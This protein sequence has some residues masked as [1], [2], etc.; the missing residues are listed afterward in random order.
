MLPEVNQK[1]DILSAYIGSPLTEEQKEFASD[2][3]Q[4]TVSFSDP[5]TGKTHTI[6][7]GLIV[8][9]TYHGVPGDKINCMSFTRA[10]VSEVA[11]R[12]EKLCK[13][14][15]VSPT[16]KF[17]TFHALSRVILSD[18]YNREMRIV[19]F[20]AKQDL[21]MIIGYMN[22]EGYTLS[23]DDKDDV[24]YARKVLRAINTLNS[25]LTFHPENV[26][27]R[28]EFV[29]LGMDI[30]KFTNIRT[31]M[32]VKG[33][34]SKEI[35]VG[36]IPLYCLYALMKRPEVVAK[37]QNKYR[38]MVVDEF[39]DMSLLHLQ[40]LS[41]IAQTLVVIGDMKQQIY[42]FNGA[43][44]QIVAAYRTMRPDARTV[45]LTQSFRCGQEVADFATRVILPNDRSIVPFKGHNRGSSVSIV[46]RRDLDWKQIIGELAM[47]K[48]VDGYAGMTDIMFLYRNNASAIPIIEELYKN[49][50]SFRCSKFAKVMD[51]PIFDTLSILAN[52]AWQPNNIDYCEKAMRLF[53]EFRKTNFGMLT[54]PVQAM[55]A[56]G[57]NIFEV[58]YRYQEQSSK[59]ILLAM[60]QAAKA[61]E[62]NSHAGNVY[63]KLL[64]VYQKYIRKYEFWKIDNKDEF[65]ISL[66]A[67][68][69]NNKT[70]PLMV[71]EEFEKEQKNTE[72]TLADFGVRCYTMHSCKG[73]EADD[74]Y[75][76]DADEG[77]FPN[78][79]MLEEKVKAH[80]YRDAAT[81]IRSE[82]NLLYVAITRAKRNVIISYS[83]AEVTKLISDPENDKYK[84][85]DEY[86]NKDIIEYNDVEEFFKLFKIGDYA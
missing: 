37:W 60:M 75:I 43:C 23:T 55:K 76:L 54:A 35:N 16:V 28:H 61:I 19:D 36:D 44:P 85:W 12:Y 71:N 68:I 84:Q 79:K 29:S 11:G 72:A 42:E 69:A 86:Y 63:M 13:K 65:Y 56:S 48:K 26:A 74:V 73:L 8:A 6:V 62:N 22:Q 78:S 3:T 53:P 57:K 5:G 10:A 4:N 67:P 64:N 9:Q 1:L 83:G 33:L 47:Q 52:A 25:S 15:S 27:S 34:I 39:Q 80:C 59:D 21:E 49:G 51:I 81:N 30:D 41:F 7:A 2:F 70:Y 82:R 31:N 24:A 46:H 20:S 58:A 45:S 77:T 40:I 17:N 18:A 50:I 14:C 38:I 66:V 32:F